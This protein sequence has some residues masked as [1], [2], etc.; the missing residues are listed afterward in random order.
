MNQKNT[1]IVC[2]SV[3]RTGKFT[4]LVNSE[5]IRHGKKSWIITPI[6]V[7]LLTHKK[8]IAAAYDYFNIGG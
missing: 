6:Y 5:V 4:D 8:A 7:D 3:K 1:S 2:L